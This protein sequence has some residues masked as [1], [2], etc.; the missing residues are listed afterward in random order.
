MKIVLL[1]LVLGAAAMWFF[2]RQRKPNAIDLRCTYCGNYYASR[3]D[4]AEGQMCR[5]CYARRQGA[6]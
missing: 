5:S 3:D 1:L 2:R 6:G 4:F